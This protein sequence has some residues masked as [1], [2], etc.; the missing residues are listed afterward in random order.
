VGETVTIPVTIRA[1]WEGIISVG[2]AI[3]VGGTFAFGLMRA[4]QRR[5]A[6]KRAIENGE[7]VTA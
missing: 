4:I 7:E 2:L 3:V 5:R 6:D 1:G